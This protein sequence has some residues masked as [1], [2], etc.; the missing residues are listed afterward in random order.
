MKNQRKAK[1]ENLLPFSIVEFWPS[2]K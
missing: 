1:A 2:I